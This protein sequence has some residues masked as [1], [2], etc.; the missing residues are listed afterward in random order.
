MVFFGTGQLTE[1]RS[2]LPDTMLCGNIIGFTRQMLMEEVRSA[3][4]RKQML[5]P[6]AKQAAEYLKSLKMQMAK[7]DQIERVVL[8]KEIRVED[9]Y[10][11]LL[12]EMK[13]RLGEIDKE[14]ND[15]NRKI[16]D[17][18]ARKDVVIVPQMQMIIQRFMGEKQ[19]IGKVINDINNFRAETK[20][21]AVKGLRN[22]RI[23]KG[24]A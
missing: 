3:N 22:N 17:K 11:K 23:V 14:I 7:L 15:M 2:P 24:Y 20:R 6:N 4:M 8:T 12:A 13:K 21:S 9:A 1:L 18:R 16:N 10:K 19:E 5:R